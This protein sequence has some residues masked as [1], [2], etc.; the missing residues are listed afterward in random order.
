MSRNDPSLKPS[1]P[2]RLGHP[3]RLRPETQELTFLVIGLFAVFAV[4][5]AHDEIVENL[6][7]AGWIVA[8]Q[9]EK[10]EL[11]LGAVLLVVW[12]FIIVRLVGIV[13]NARAPENGG[14]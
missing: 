1:D 14:S 7:A 4:M 12:S 10:Y 6:V 9:A 8:A 2:I 3:S 11:I 13:R 5:M